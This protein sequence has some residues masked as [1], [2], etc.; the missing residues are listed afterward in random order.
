MPPK[1]LTDPTDSHLLEQA[2]RDAIASASLPSLVRSGR[3]AVALRLAPGPT[4]GARCCQAP[5]LTNPTFDE[6]GS[7]PAEVRLECDRSA[8][9]SGDRQQRRASAGCPLARPRDTSET[10]PRRQQRGLLSGDCV[11]LTPLQQRAGGGGGGGGGMPPPPPQLSSAPS[12]LP[13]GWVEYFAPGGGAPYYHHAPTGTTTWE[14]P[15]P[16][17]PQA[18]PAGQGPAGQGPAG[19]GQAGQGGGGELEAE[20]VLG[21]PLVVKCDSANTAAETVARGGEWRVDRLANQL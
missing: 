2:S 5:V 11:A 21:M 6:T 17:P 20:V 18:G 1:D 14:R 16:P 15:A 10:R 4:G 12:A 13:A 9:P 8:A 7:K 3:A 19:Q